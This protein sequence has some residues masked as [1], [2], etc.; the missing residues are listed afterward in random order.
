MKYLLHYFICLVRYS[1][2][3][4]AYYIFYF[5]AIFVFFIALNCF[6]SHR[7]KAPSIL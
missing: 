5:T 6:Y 4:Y 2:V 3:I 7:E 1:H